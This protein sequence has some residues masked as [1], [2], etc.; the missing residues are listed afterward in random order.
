MHVSKAAAAKGVQ[1]TALLHSPFLPH[2]PAHFLQGTPVLASGQH[3]M[4]SAEIS[5]QWRMIISLLVLEVVNGYTVHIIQKSKL[6]YVRD[7][8]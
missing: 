3:M 4:C 5:I 2:S 1:K 7:K 6:V 8:Q